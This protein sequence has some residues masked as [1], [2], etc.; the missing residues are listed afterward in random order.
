MPLHLSRIRRLRYS[1]PRAVVTFLACHSA[2][3]AAFAADPGVVVL[4]IDTDRVAGAI[5]DERINGQR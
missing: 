1:L 5:Y 2:A 3:T 4:L